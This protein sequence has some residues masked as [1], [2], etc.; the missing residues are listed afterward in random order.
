MGALFSSPRGSIV[1]SVVKGP[2]RRR[3]RLVLGTRAEVP[4]AS[5]E[6]ARGSVSHI[7]D[8][9]LSSHRDSVLGRRGCAT[10]SLVDHGQ[11]CS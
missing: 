6:L 7:G 1:R 11:S 3:A 4:S 9:F 5:D 10:S 2:L 8:R